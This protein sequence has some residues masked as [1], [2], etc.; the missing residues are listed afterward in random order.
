MPRYITVST[1]KGGT[2]KTTVAY[3]LA[4]KLA[5]KYKILLIDTDGQ[6]NTTNRC[7]VVIG[8]DDASIYDIYKNKLMNWV[9]PA[10]EDLIVKSPIKNLKKLDL[11][12]ASSYMAGGGRDFNYMA[13]RAKLK[14]N[15]NDRICSLDFALK[16][17]FD[18]YP[19][20]F[21]QYDYI[22]FDTN[23][24]KDF[25]TVSTYIVAD[26]ILIISDT[27]KDSIKGSEDVCNLWDGERAVF[28][29][30]YNYI[31][32]DNIDG[33]IINNY[34]RR[35]TTSSRNAKDKIEGNEGIN[36]LLIKT[37]IP[38]NKTLKDTAEYKVPFNIMLKNKKL[39]KSQQFLVD[40]FDLLIKELKEREVL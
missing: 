1:L 22:I 23:P 36:E 40:T 7:G 8:K 11:L 25:Y 17:F 35:A 9:M 34:D 13:K 12:P 28:A 5:E 31:I 32:D 24:A 2:G 16:D 30:E 29:E 39:N 10:P 14:G 3:N 27:S 15:V 26:S 19:E 18:A 20:Y 4:G 33:I 21:S 38:S 37:M 6:C